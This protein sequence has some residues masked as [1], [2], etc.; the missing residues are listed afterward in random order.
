MDESREHDVVSISGIARPKRVAFL[1]NPDETALDELDYLTQWC[2]QH[3]GGG[4]WPIVPSD[5]KTVSADW[6]NVLEAIDPDII[7][8]VCDLSGSLFD[9]IHR[10][11]A[12]SLLENLG[13]I[14]NLRHHGIA[15][16]V[17]RDANALDVFHLVRFHAVRQAYMRNAY[18]LR[19][20][21]SPAPTP[22]RAFA[23]RNFGLVQDSTRTRVV[24]EA[25]EVR[26]LDLATS[27]LSPMDLLGTLYKNVGSFS[28]VRELAT[29]YAP[30]AYDPTWD[31]LSDAFQ[32][33]VGD[34]VDDVL[35][36]W[37]RSLTSPG[38]T[39]KDVLWID[40]ET[41][42]DAASLELIGRWI[43]RFYFHNNQRH[44]L[45]VSHTVDDEE[46]KRIAEALRKPSWMYFQ[47]I[48]L[49]RGQTRFKKR[50]S[51]IG[52]HYPAAFDRPTA[53]AELVNL[54]GRRGLL[55]APQPPFPTESRGADGWMVDL[56]IEYNLDPARYANQHDLW[57][58]PK[59]ARL[60]ALFGK[61]TPQARIV[62]E[63]QPSLPAIPTDQSLAIRIPSKWEVLRVLLDSPPTSEE[64]LG[65]PWEETRPPYPH[66]SISE[67]G[68]RFRGLLGLLGSLGGAIHVFRSH[69]WRK[70]FADLAPKVTDDRERRAEII[71][72]ELRTAINGTAMP[73]ADPL[74]IEGVAQT[75][76][77]KLHL[78]PS[79]SL[80][81]SRKQLVDQ[82]NKL[83]GTETIITERGERPLTFDDDAS[84]DLE[85]LLDVGAFLQGISVHC[86]VCDWNQWV[87]VDH[88]A[89]QVICEGCGKP[90]SLD[91]SPTWMFRLNE[92]IGSAI[93]RD[94]VLPVLHMAHR[95]TR[96][97]RSLGLTIE[98]QDLYKSY[99]GQK[100]TDLD[101]IVICDGRFIIGEVKSSASGFKDSDFNK[102]G[103][104]AKSILPDEVVVAAVGA[105]WP[106][107]VEK[108]IQEMTSDLAAHEVA[109]NPILLEW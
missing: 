5:G 85:W 45:V 72:R 73:G 63:G 2:A 62:G 50:D 104:V 29:L 93:S 41:A 79:R 99:G 21:D 13:P 101:V 15:R 34:G 1:I 28:T 65:K 24:F 52:L 54:S 18:F 83:R 36:T 37:N 20:K 14:S 78:V 53:H 56:D 7:C 49:H 102:L 23:I 30:R 33:I 87:H 46:L 27:E 66:F 10:R 22:T 19:L 11:L 35:Q 55:R 12:P 109:V 69:Y 100:V 89:R 3:W 74:N 91:S 26:R 106:A 43:G 60:G 105:S 98:P 96:S 76:A 82:F 6:W 59:R 25:P 67:Q 47:P 51:K 61:W 70:V 17:S 58:L 9:R 103:I 92:L 32:L 88:I 68:R 94:A 95:L 44:G 108:L 77:G 84:R 57:R 48:G 90:F 107:E 86:S 39:G 4:F 97:A 64:S 42:R 40:V 16:V 75:I 31:Q 71:A 81:I 38:W 8:T 80:G